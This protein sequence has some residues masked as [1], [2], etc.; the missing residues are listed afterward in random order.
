MLDKKIMNEGR[1][2]NKKGNEKVKS[3]TQ[4]LPHQLLDNFLKAE[5]LNAKVSR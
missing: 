2:E 3:H 1:K 4:F 5:R